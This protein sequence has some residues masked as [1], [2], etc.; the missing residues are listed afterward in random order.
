MLFRNF[1]QDAGGGGFRA[2]GSTL[3]GDEL[4]LCSENGAKNFLPLRIIGELR[5]AA[6][7]NAFGNRG[8]HSGTGANAFHHFALQT[9]HF[10]SGVASA[11]REVTIVVN[12]NEAFFPNPLPHFGF[13]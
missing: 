11:R 3:Q 4:I 10:G 7:V 8:N 1:A 2:A 13:N 9:D 5:I 12:R 6:E